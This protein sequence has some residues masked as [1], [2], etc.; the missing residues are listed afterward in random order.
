MVSIDSRKPSRKGHPP[1]TKKGAKSSLKPPK[2]LP[3]KPKT[4]PADLRNRS[5]WVVWRYIWNP[6]KTPKDGRGEKGDWD[7][8]PFCVSTGGRASSTDPLTWA[9][10]DEALTAYREGGW[11]GI[12]FIPTPED[13][14]VIIDLD[15][16][17]DPKAR[18]IKKWAMRIVREMNTYTEI[19]P[20]GTGLRIVAFG[21][22]PDRERCKKGAVEIYDG[23]TK[24]GKPGGRYLTFTG[25]RLGGSPAEVCD[26]QEAL[27]AVY[28]RE[29][30][31][32]PARGH[33]ANGKKPNVEKA[34]SG[35]SPCSAQTPTLSDEEIIRR[36]GRAK[37]GEK[38]K[39][40]WDGDRS[41]YA[42]PSE[43]DLAMCGMLAFWTGGD[44][45]HIDRLFRKSRLMRPKWDREDYRDRTIAK[46]LQGQRKC[47]TPGGDGTDKEGAGKPSQATL[48]VS[49]VESA[50][51][52]LFH[53]PD[54]EAYVTLPR[55]QHYA[56]G[57]LGTKW[58]KQWMRRL[59]YERTKRTPGAQALQD[60]L[61]VLEGKA[62]FDGA[63]H[64]VH[65]RVAAAEGK[66]Y[67]DLGNRCRQAVKIDATGWRVVRRPRIKFRRTKAML[68]LP[69]PKRDGS[70]TDLWRFVN[71]AKRD[72][73]LVL[74]WLVAAMRGVG[75]FP[76]LCLYGEQGSAKSTTTRV[77][78]SL[79]DPNTAPVRVEPR[80]MRDLAVGADNSWVIAF[81]NVS[82]LPIWR[83]DAL[84]RLSTGGGF[85]T[86]T[87][88][89]NKE[90]TI[91][92][93]KRPAILNG[94]EEV[95]VRGDLLDRAV[96]I[97]CP[98]IP[99]DRRK[100]EA[101]FWEAFE[102]AR[103]GILGALLDAISAGLAK[104]PS[105]KLGQMPRMADFARWA[106]ACEEG[107]G[108]VEGSFLKAYERNRCTANEAALESS[109]VVKH[110]LFLVDDRNWNGTAVELLMALGRLATEE[111]K[112]L[113]GWP[114]GANHL[115][116]ILKR[117]APNLRQAGIEVAF[118]MKRREGKVQRIIT[119]ERTGI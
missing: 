85:G 21:H 4:I 98:V 18:R 32:P 118:R 62:V 108:L 115:S 77:L 119:L 6:D 52:E 60:A 7:K 105:V 95:V 14:L 64:R 104:L 40:L 16:C 66:V 43:A 107:L 69:V 113:K 51:V 89:E 27:S 103:P 13:G 73:P 110:I 10:F 20:S 58:F 9:T 76:I 11:D 65:V 84:C 38:F 88:Y 99:E 48:I 57:L 86:R 54:E 23:M 79:V 63:E 1:A 111:E 36:A 75:P 3:V 106:V 30:K 37:N 35:N 68:G 59:F 19:S 41:G 101:E 39:K 102:A 29:L 12:G 26:R 109:P 114:K 80:D 61:G 74:A 56:T 34:R 72:R 5:Q 55:E 31:G 67:L 116:G 17:R 92:S 112:R 94:I 97:S 44:A 117:L 78:R 90:E 93:A 82:F 15:A 96:L 91:F 71:V 33:E 46:A 87:L 2:A 100:T 47:Y 45:A 70:L 81:D 8:P 50:G 22:K 83:S 49:M 28:E 42:S 24:D 53:D 25:H